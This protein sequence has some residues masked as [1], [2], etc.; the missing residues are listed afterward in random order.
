MNWQQSFPTCLLL[1]AG[2]GGV[3]DEGLDYFP[4]VGVYEASPAQARVDR[5]FSAFKIESPLAEVKDRLNI[6]PCEYDGECE[7]RDADGVRHYFFDDLLVVKRVDAADFVGRPILALGIG[8]ARSRREV[9][10]AAQ[11]FLPDVDFDCRKWKDDRQWET[12]QAFLVPGH[13]TIEFDK[14]GLLVELDLSGYH[15][16]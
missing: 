2:C 13:V 14:Q 10:M 7:W 5:S 3:A 8:M 16:T 15:F 11:R 9:M 4:A 12:C 6:I 1:L